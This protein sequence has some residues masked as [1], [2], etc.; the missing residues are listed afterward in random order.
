M[1]KIT[2]EY[3]L[4]KISKFEN[5]KKIELNNYLQKLSKYIFSIERGNYFI[6]YLFDKLTIIINSEKGKITNLIK[7]EN[8]YKNYIYDYKNNIKF[9]ID[10]TIGCIFET[11]KTCSELETLNINKK[12]FNSSQNIKNLTREVL[13]EYLNFSG[14]F[15]S[16]LYLINT[17]YLS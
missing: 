3:Y 10:S 7:T 13:N 5:L 14:D 11:L 2:N 4:S 6:N 12:L 1:D 9:E 17:N 8:S 16:F 15:K